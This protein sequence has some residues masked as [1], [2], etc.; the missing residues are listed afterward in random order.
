[1]Y[2]CNTTKITYLHG[3]KYRKLLHICNKFLL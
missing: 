2:S 3:L 1:M